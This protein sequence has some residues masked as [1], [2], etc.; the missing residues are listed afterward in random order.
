[1]S[2]SAPPSNSSQET[3]PL[4]QDHENQ[5]NVRA[6]EPPPPYN[7]PPPYTETKGVPLPNMTP[8]PEYKETPSSIPYAPTTTTVFVVPM[9]FNSKPSEVLCPHCNVPVMTRIEHEAGTLTWLLCCFVS[10]FVLCCNFTKDVNHYCPICQRRLGR[11]NRPCSSRI[12][13]FVVLIIAISI[14]LNIMRAM[15]ESHRYG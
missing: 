4:T 5:E 7:P 12:V 8:P 3:T 11:Y 6:Q 13:M 10:I 1:M 15:G 14:V 9:E 2:M